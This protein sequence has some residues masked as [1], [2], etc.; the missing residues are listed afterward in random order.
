MKLELLPYNES[1]QLKELGFDWPCDEFYKVETGELFDG[2]DFVDA[3]NHNAYPDVVS[4]PT[5]D[6]ACKWLRDVKKIDIS[7][8]PFLSGTKI[9]YEG[10]VYVPGLE[11]PKEMQDTYG[12]SDIYENAQIDCIKVAIKYLQ[13]QTN[14]TRPGTN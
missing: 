10:T 12:I 6:L 7:I 5:L 2:G 13:K 3:E 11:I 4:A 8:E 9:I 1:F 14:D